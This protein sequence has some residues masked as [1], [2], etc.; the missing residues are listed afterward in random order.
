ML[1]PQL[2]QPGLHILRPYDASCCYG[3]FRHSESKK[4]SKCG[5]GSSVQEPGDSQTKFLMCE[6]M[7]WTLDSQSGAPNGPWSVLAPQY[8]AWPTMPDEAEILA[9]SKMSHVA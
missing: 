6:K 9:N 3:T 5:S 4:A 1:L 7:I 8:T 2:D